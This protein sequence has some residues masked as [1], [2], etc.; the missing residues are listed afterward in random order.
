MKYGLRIKRYPRIRTMCFHRDSHL[1]ITY[2]RNFVTLFCGRCS[3]KRVSFSCDPRY[4][5]NDFLEEK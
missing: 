1:L 4:K 5:I 3:A 2:G